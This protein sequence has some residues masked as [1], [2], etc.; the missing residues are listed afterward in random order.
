MALGLTERLKI[1]FDVETQS[2]KQ[3]VKS[4]KA[5]M[6]SADGVVAK[7]KV[8]F[9]ALK[10]QLA[11]FGPAAA[12]AG[13][14]I[15]V[16]FGKKAVDAFT[17]TALAAGQLSDATTLSTED[18][19]RWL[20]VSDSVGISAETMTGAFQKMNVAVANGAF[21]K[22]GIDVQ[23]ASDG[24]M[25]A[26]ATMQVAL[27]TIGKIPD[28]AERAKAAQAVFGRSYGEIARLIEMKAGDLQQAL[29]D[30]TDGQLITDGEVAKARDYQAAMDDL[31]DSV[32]ELSLK[33]GGELAPALG[34]AAESASKLIT[35]LTN[36]PGP[37]KGVVG[38]LL[39]MALPVEDVADGFAQV[40][41]GSSTW[42]ERLT[43]LGKTIP[44]V[45]TAVDNLAN[46][47]SGGSEAMEFGFIKNL[48]VSRQEVGNLTG[49]ID[50]LNTLLDATAGLADAAAKA[51]QELNDQL[52]TAADNARGADRAM[53]DYQEQLA[54]YGGMLL[55]GTASSEELSDAVRD[56]ADGAIEAA[57][58]YAE[59]AVAADSS[60]DYTDEFK[61]SLGYLADTLE[62]GSPLRRQL[63]QYLATLDQIPT[64]IV[65]AVSIVN[66]NTTFQLPNGQLIGRPAGAGGTHIMS[67]SELEQAALAAWGAAGGGT[68]GGSAG[69]QHEMSP[70]RLK[71]LDDWDEWKKRYER[72]HGEDKPKIA[73]Q[74][75]KFL[76]KIAKL[77]PKFSDE[78]MAIWREIQQVRKDRNAVRAERRERRINRRIKAAATAAEAAGE[79]WDF[80]GLAAGGTGSSSTTG[81]RA[82]VAVTVNMPHA[83]VAD[84]RA[85]R[86][87][88]QAAAPAISH[89]LR[90]YHEGDA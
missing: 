61:K 15:A 54:T 84:G 78:G 79:P 69:G 66:G 80:D 23:R 2:F 8:G 18:A 46:A 86:E 88:L 12:L 14:A 48:E 74:Y 41:D 67:A 75:L 50:A 20:E 6:A 9:G 37:V 10:D 19:S 11:T 39:D 45:G 55:E 7:S 59:S 34:G 70:E 28:A 13:A 17:Q 64:D 85:M 90:R 29:A 76:Y 83:L 42:K 62:P 65:T 44:W 72:S 60:K 1:I 58:A 32:H 47:I 89:A 22:Y 73:G 35:S 52:F 43:G 38:N 3:G 57:K 68:G 56:T 40:I 36:M 21:A 5:E 16:N 49:P 51:Q 53:D 81:G 25:D 82:A 87:A 30:V 71:A 27:A 24:T 4:L 77:F 33:L 26:N 31:G 63:E